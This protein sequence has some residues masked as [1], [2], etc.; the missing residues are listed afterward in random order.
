MPDK[1]SK[2]LNLS[3]FLPCF[4]FSFNP[5]ILFFLL[6]FLFSLSSGC[7]ENKGHKIADIGE[8]APEFTL[9]DLNGKMV[10]LREYKGRYV[11]LNFWAT[12]C[13][14]CVSEMPFLQEIY[15]KEKDKGITV[16]GIDY[17]EDQEKVKKFLSKYGIT[18]TILMDNNL[19]V[20]KDYG[21]VGLPVTFLIDSEGRI[22]KK[23][24]GELT[25]EIY[26]KYLKSEISH[27]KSS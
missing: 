15:N 11:I 6:P 21:V 2:G 26:N 10:S 7:A 3:I 22:K 12:W 13:P 1:R 16:I 20:S 14:S 27:L 18:F 23:F 17:N 5:F 9:T 8:P 24:R 4:Q 25:E 19:K